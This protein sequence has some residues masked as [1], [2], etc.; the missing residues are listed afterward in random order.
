MDDEKLISFL[1]QGADRKGAENSEH[2]KGL[3]N[4]ILGDKKFILLPF[5]PKSSGTFIRNI[6]ARYIGA[7]TVTFAYS[8][9]RGNRDI[10]P[11][12]L[13]KLCRE[14]KKRFFV[15]HQH[16]FA[17]PT[18]LDLI[19][20]WNMKVIYINRPILDCINSLIHM[21]ERSYEEQ[22]FPK[23]YGG[24]H[25]LGGPFL[26]DMT[27]SERRSYILK[28]SMH[29]YLAYNLMWL[30][31]KNRL[32]PE[33]YL[34][35]SYSK[36]AEDDLQ[37]VARMLRFAGIRKVDHAKLETIKRK[38]LENPDK[39]RLRKGADKSTEDEFSS[40]DLSFF[41]N[42]LDP[43]S[44]ILEANNL[45]RK[46]SPPRYRRVFSNIFGRIRKSNRP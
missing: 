8:S 2:L 1:T 6:M 18:N 45:L 43:V 22:G 21:V 14:E 37:A 25:F 23:K 10:Y 24:F 28:S 30:Q 16:M 38:L 34:E 15:A 36:I 7:R 35:V 12:K 41:Y 4:E 9:R 32:G 19:E 3:E 29:W 39:I 13:V 44:D 40:K 27:L 20:Q 26:E 5:A 46:R 11:P 42:F 17:Y 33:R 31:A